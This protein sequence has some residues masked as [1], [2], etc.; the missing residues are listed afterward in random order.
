MLRERAAGDLDERLGYRRRD[1]MEARGEAAGQ[2]CDGQA[3]ANRTF[4]PSKSKRNRTSSRPADR[5]GGTE[6]PMILGVEHQKAAAA[7]A[8]EFAAERAVAP[9]ELVPL[10]DLRVAH[11]FRA[12][13]L[14]LPV[15]VHQLA[16]P[17]GIG[18]LERQRGC[19][20]RD[21]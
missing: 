6:A 12:A 1:G 20:G 17:R 14:V 11:P 19:D 10:V 8:D 5:H 9:P 16:E 2:D 21:P 3:H 7:R 4:V 13:L 15:L 18:L